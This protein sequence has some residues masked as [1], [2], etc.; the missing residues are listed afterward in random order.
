MPRAGSGFLRRSFARKPL[1]GAPRSAANALTLCLASSWE[2][3]AGS[4]PGVSVGAAA[5]RP[6]GAL[7]LP[8]GAVP[9][10]ERGGRCAG[11]G[12]Q[13][14]S[15]GALES[16]GGGVPH[17]HAD[18]PAGDLQP[19]LPHQVLREPALVAGGIAVPLT[20]VRGPGDGDELD[21]V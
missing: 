16:W 15:D 20:R 6:D 3:W 18:L 8:A 21:E 19:E 5:A 7:A 1:R 10:G 2:G 11:P 17:R 12:S 9:G 14:Q 4:V 13:A